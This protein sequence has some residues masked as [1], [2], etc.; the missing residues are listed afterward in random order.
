MHID[1]DLNSQMSAPVQA[2]KQQRSYVNLNYKT[3]NK[4]KKQTLSTLPTEKVMNEQEGWKLVAAASVLDHVIL[5]TSI[6]AD[7]K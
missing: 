7:T 4:N 5:T 2:V 6:E 1:H 3:K